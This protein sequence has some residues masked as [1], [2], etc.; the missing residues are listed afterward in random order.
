MF[1][2]TAFDA[3][4]DGSVK[5]TLNF[6][7]LLDDGAEENLSA[8]EG[9]LCGDECE[10]D[11][12]LDA[13]F[14]DEDDPE[15]ADDYFPGEPITDID[16]DDDPEE[17]EDDDYDDIVDGTDTDGFIEGFDDDDDP[18]EFEDDEIGD[19][20][21]T[22]SKGKKANES[23]FDDL[24]S[25]DDIATE[26]FK[27]GLTSTITTVGELSTVLSSIDAIIVGAADMGIS[28]V[29]MAIASVFE[30]VAYTNGIKQLREMA[31]KTDD[32][33]KKK[34][35][36]DRATR[37]EHIRDVMSG[38]QRKTPLDESLNKPNVMDR[39]F[40]WFQEISGGMRDIYDRHLDKSAKKN[41]AKGNTALATRQ[42]ALLAYR[43][44]MTV[45]S[46]FD[47]LFTDDDIATEGSAFEPKMD[48]NNF[49]STYFDDDLDLENDTEKGLVL[50]DDEEDDEDEDD[51]G[52][53]LGLEG[54]GAGIIAGSIGAAVGTGV[55][56][57][58][59]LGIEK[60]ASMINDKKIEDKTGKEMRTPTE[61]ELRD[62]YSAALKASTVV[63]K[64]VDSIAE[65]YVIKRNAI[66][67]YEPKEKAIINKM[68]KCK[69][70]IGCV[71]AGVLMPTGTMYSKSTSRNY[72]A[73]INA[74]KD[75]IA[76]A[77]PADI[78]TY[79]DGGCITIY[80]VLK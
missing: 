42:K 6:D 9:T 60:L 4:K 56:T 41:E 10:G 18:E 40:G 78:E 21:V 8:L 61:D 64:S 2:L 45:E 79:V 14:E 53:E 44:A 70:A 76:N 52:V 19:I 47:D 28:V 66:K 73:A 46:V 25:E 37:A 22:K 48:R 54:I 7:E 12:C 74:L 36:L 50:F 43:N 67:Y 33:K 55:A 29:D 1:G 3:I 24:F 51:M 75:K 16:D 72:T 30:K 39:V 62:F 63:A 71:V 17:E 59:V 23:I 26:G 11:E 49:D 57:G 80:K 58:T 31:K 35:L 27:S 68:R 5:D 15:D 69:G 65:K 20:K 34:K 32:E 13:D 38:I 77:L